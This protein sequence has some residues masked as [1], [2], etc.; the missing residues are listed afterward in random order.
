MAAEPTKVNLQAQNMPIKDVIEKLSQQAGVSIVLDPKATGNVSASLG[1]VE[2]NE[3]LDAITK[4]NKL[5]WKKLGFAKSER[6]TVKLDQ[7]RSAIVALASMPL[8][9]LS[10]DD[11]STKQSTVFAKDLPASPDVSTIKL[12]EGYS[13]VTVYVILAPE[14]AAT[15]TASAVT[16][17]P[18]A[19]QTQIGN[20]RMAELAKMTPE[21]RK[22]VFANEWA[23]QM[24]LGPDQSR[25]MLKDRFQAVSS[26]D[27][28]FQ[29]Q[30]RQDMRSVYK[31]MRRSG[32]GLEKQKKGNGTKR[33]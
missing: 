20:Q 18:V 27:P 29:S 9:G 6:D 32:Q 21:E 31:D 19:S 25:T 26:L 13:W 3:A 10:V 33:Q 1:G 24:S 12:P 23:Y 7:L 8:V 22:Q 2:L 11:P 15:K 17:D 5:T 14:A 16:G 4:L 28:Q 30:F